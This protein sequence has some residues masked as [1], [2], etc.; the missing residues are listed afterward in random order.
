MLPIRPISRKNIAA[1]G[2]LGSRESEWLQAII[3]KIDGK[4]GPE[5]LWINGVNHPLPEHSDGVCRAIRV[6]PFLE[7]FQTARCGDLLAD[8]S[9]HV[10]SEDIL[11]RVLLDFFASMSEDHSTS[12]QIARNPALEKEPQESASSSKIPVLV[13]LAL[14]LGQSGAESI[15]THVVEGWE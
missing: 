12:C 11:V 14:A 10:Y 2:R 1:N 7:R 6:I 9:G 13:L 5:V 15:A 4:Y 8:C 3:V